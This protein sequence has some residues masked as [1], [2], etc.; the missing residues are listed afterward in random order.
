MYRISADRSPCAWCPY[1]GRDKNDPGCVK[2][3][4][5]VEYAIRMGAIAVWED[6]EEDINLREEEHSG[7]RLFDRSKLNPRVIRLHEKIKFLG[8]EGPEDFIKAQVLK[9]L[10]NRE[11][12][13][14]IGA[15]ISTVSKWKREYL[16]EKK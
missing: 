12:A 3:D 14:M 6:Q 13:D 15:G 7:R 5:R 2:C 16:K 9:K 8:F 10:K 4:S 1:L 11:I